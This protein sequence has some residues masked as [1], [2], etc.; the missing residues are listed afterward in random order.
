MQNHPDFAVLDSLAGQLKQVISNAN[1]LGRLNTLERN[2][3]SNQNYNTGRYNQLAKT[4]LDFKMFGPDICELVAKH[5]PELQTVASD[6]YSKYERIVNDY[7]QQRIDKNKAIDL[8]I[9]NHAE[10]ALRKKTKI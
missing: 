7:V 8:A 6:Y 10:A 9:A 1:I 2:R 4:R 3:R 5:Y